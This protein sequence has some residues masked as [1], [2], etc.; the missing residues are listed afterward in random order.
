MTISVFCK[1]INA[2]THVRVL[3][4]YGFAGEYTVKELEAE[5]NAYTPII[6]LKAYDYDIIFIVIDRL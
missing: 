3:D 1:I 6:E 5:F 2:Y 4:R